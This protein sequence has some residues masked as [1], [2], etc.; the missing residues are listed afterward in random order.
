LKSRVSPSL[1]NE[2]GLSKPGLDKPGLSNLG[3]SVLGLE[4]S[5]PVEGRK[6][7]FLMLGLLKRLS[8]SGRDLEV[9]RP[10]LRPL[11]VLLRKVF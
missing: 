5:V 4:L 10:A 6:L 7:D 2:R 3:R 1:P 8:A 9:A 11:S